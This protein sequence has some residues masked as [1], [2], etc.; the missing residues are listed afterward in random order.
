[1]AKFY[2]TTPI[3]YVNDKPHIGHAYTSLAADVLARFHRLKGDDVFFLTGTDEHGQKVERAAGEKKISPQDF[4]D[5]VSQ[6]FRDLMVV[7]NCSPDDFIRTTEQRHKKACQL[8]WQKL[9]DG[10][11]IYKGN[12]E[13][14]YAV[15]DE[16][17]YQ[18]SELQKN[19]DGQYIAPSG[20]EAIWVREE[21][22]FFKLSSFQEKLLLYYEKHPDFIS[23]KIRANEVIS[24]VKGGLRD[25]SISRKNFSWGIP[26]ADDA[27]HVMYVWLDALTNYL[28]A[29]GYADDE[30]LFKKL[31]PCDLHLVGKDILRFHA[32]Y[33]PAI[34]MAL[35][36]PL[37]KKIFAHG[38]WMN[39]GQ[40]MSKSIGNVID[41]D[42]LI[43]KFGRDQVRYFLLRQVPFGDD[44]D[45]S[46]TMLQQRC[47]HDLANDLGNLAQRS[48]SLID[49][50]LDGDFPKK[51]II[52]ED[53]EKLLLMAKN[54]LPE[55]EKHLKEL[56]FH[57]ALESIWAVIGEANRFIDKS[58]PW[59]LA[60]TDKVA[61]AGVLWVMLMVIKDVAIILQCFIP[62]SAMKLLTQLGVDERYFANLGKD[63]HIGKKLPTPNAIFPRII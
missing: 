47:N 41:P 34:L 17:Y 11:F 54:M 27:N 40:K 45:F 10:G 62:E 15:R 63:Y 3:Y 9:V 53:G 52:S 60:K 39:N 32:V 30:N 57:R 44:G 21:S 8:L 49:K 31:W 23:P 36:L 37:P 50:H 26:V 25:L 33:W 24:F 2:I 29:V 19:S 18:E 7:M 4:T 58:A 38:W 22:Y 59:A 56:A 48:L 28:T 13:G 1:M 46:E 51:S 14:F 42:V 35:D 6:N 16:A 12:Y 61:M 5:Q 43:K 55:V 20:A